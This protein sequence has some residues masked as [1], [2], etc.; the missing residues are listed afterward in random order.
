MSCS[1]VPAIP[2][3]RAFR[4]QFHVPSI[5]NFINRTSLQAAECQP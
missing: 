4:S 2:T 5:A 3:L 1:P